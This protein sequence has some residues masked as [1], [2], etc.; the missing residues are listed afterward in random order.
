M[1]LYCRQTK[2]KRRTSTIAGR[3]KTGEAT[4]VKWSDFMIDASLSESIAATSRHWPHWTGDKVLPWRPPGKDQRH[5]H[6]SP[7]ASP[8]SVTL[9][10][11]AA[12][13]LI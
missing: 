1:R 8:D 7:S 2:V 9:T 13:L 11:P 6:M 12:Q 3:G 4:M 10:L 5:W